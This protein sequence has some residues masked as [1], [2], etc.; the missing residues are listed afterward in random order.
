MK[1]M[2]LP[3]LLLFIAPKS[4]AV[5]PDIYSPIVTFSSYTG[6][7]TV[8]VSM[9]NYLYSDVISSLANASGLPLKIY[10]D[11][12][13][14]YKGYNLFEKKLEWCLK[15]DVLQNGTQNFKPIIVQVTGPIT[16]PNITFTGDAY[17]VTINHE[18]GTVLSSVDNR[19]S[20]GNG[21]PPLSFTDCKIE[22]EELTPDFSSPYVMLVGHGRYSF[23]GGA[24]AGNNNS[25]L[26]ADKLKGKLTTGIN[27]GVQIYA[28]IFPI[29]TEDPSLNGTY[30]PRLI[31]DKMMSKLSPPEQI[32]V[33]GD[34][35][36]W[37]RIIENEHCEYQGA[38]VGFFN[39]ETAST[40]VA[41]T[42]NAALIDSEMA[43]EASAIGFPYWFSIYTDLIGASNLAIEWTAHIFAT[44][45]NDN[46]SPFYNVKTGKIFSSANP[47]NFAAYEAMMKRALGSY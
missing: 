4:F 22:N 42:F 5:H 34:G 30:I 33:V 27:S 10:A 1:K 7:F 35:G 28:P 26:L 25:G 38:I 44:E 37:N 16:S 3:L 8:D 29:G 15:T 43:S 19:P 41:N 36:T 24:L 45:A 39:C 32:L 11:G 18:T 31:V 47:T 21:E 46:S 13:N 9:T 20:G 23:S 6:G 17:S 14:R 2:L 40:Y 12:P